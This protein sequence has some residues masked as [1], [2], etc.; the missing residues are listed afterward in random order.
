MVESETHPVAALTKTKFVVPGANPVTSPLS[1]IEAIL[2]LA[3]IQD[4]PVPGDNCVVD[5]TH[6]SVPPTNTVNGLG[7]IMI[8][9]VGSELQP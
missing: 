4:P 9:C 5:P 3:E 8:C 6:I 1:V 2:F 7:L